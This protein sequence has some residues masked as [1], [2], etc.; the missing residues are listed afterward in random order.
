MI[1][2]L[3]QRSAAESYINRMRSAAK[4]IY[5]MD[6]W[7]YIACPSPLYLEPDRGELS[8]MAAQAVRMQLDSILNRMRD[9]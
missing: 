6:Y 2:T 1:A 9:V 8:Y 3:G 5:A 7:N 4:R